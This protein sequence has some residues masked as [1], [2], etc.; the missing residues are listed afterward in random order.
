MYA[1]MRVLDIH[2]GH[3]N[4]YSNRTAVVWGV[5][6]NTCHVL[7]RSEDWIGVSSLGCV[8]KQQ[9][10]G[11]VRFSCDFHWMTV[12]MMVSAMEPVHLLLDVLRSLEDHPRSYRVPVMPPHLYP[13]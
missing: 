8:G 11:Q 10:N 3:G 9:R 6:G 4:P 2:G 5:I 1:C 12:M 13:K 7:D